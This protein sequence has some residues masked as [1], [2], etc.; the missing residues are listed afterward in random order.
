MGK[1]SKSQANH[2][3][4]LYNFTEQITQEKMNLNYLRATFKIEV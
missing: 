2:I 4:T 3:W 1:P